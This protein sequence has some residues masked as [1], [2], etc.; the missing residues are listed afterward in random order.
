MTQEGACPRSFGGRVR[1]E[2]QDV[3]AEN[4]ALLELCSSFEPE[5]VPRVVGAL[6]RLKHWQWQLPMAAA[7][8]FIIIVS[9]YCLQHAAKTAG[10]A[11]STWC[12]WRA[13]FF[14]IFTCCS[15]FCDFHGMLAF[16]RS[17]EEDLPSPWNQGRMGLSAA[18]ICLSSVPGNV[19][20]VSILQLLPIVLWLR[21]GFAEFAPAALLIVTIFEPL[22]NI[23]NALTFEFWAIFIRK[24]QSEF[25]DPLVQGELTVGGALRAFGRVNSHR[26]AV[27]RAVR[28]QLFFVFLFFCLQ[29]AVLLYDFELR[30]WGGWP[31]A[32]NFVTNVLV[33]IFLFEPYIQVRMCSS[34]CSPLSFL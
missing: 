29:Q 24:S 19:V 22:H 9:C 1:M 16:L 11:D 2:E 8:A 13:S 30:S 23:L 34:T 5:W 6:K 14:F 25:A 21:H 20:A 10:L 3:E 33:F 18:E 32:V 17:S 31:F 27:A 28:S 15:A 12:S 26:K 4:E 7:Q